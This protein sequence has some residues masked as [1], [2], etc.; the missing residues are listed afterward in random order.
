MIK[1]E[2]I[3]NGSTLSLK[4]IKT[5]KWMSEE[6]ICFTANIILNGKNVGYA[7]NEGH[8]GCTF[9]HFNNPADEAKALSFAKEANAN[10]FKGWEFMAEKGLSLDCLIDI[11]IER[12]DKAKANEKIIKK[13]KK[14]MLDKVVFVKE[15]EDAKMGYRILKCGAAGIEKGIIAMQ[16][17]YGKV[18]IF[19]NASDEVLVSTFC[20][21]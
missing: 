10:D 7:S 5:V 18:T 14:D 4:S 15:G 1:N 21:A 8:G 12:E 6:T 20:L 3:I 17:K 11:L 19:N 2:I 13:V 9:C 16:T